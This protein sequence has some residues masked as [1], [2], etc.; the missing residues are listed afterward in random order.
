M[1]QHRERLARWR[2][3]LRERRT[4][5][6]TYRAGV[7]LMGI[8]VLGVGVIA[9]PYPGPGWAIVFV[10]LG[11][12][13]T[14]FVWAQRLLR[15]IKA[16]YDKVMTWFGEQGLWVKAAGVALTTAVVLVTLW[17]VGALGWSARLVGIDSP[18]LKSPV[19]VG[20]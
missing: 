3:K 1:N 4:T 5:N 14:E 13:A 16:R 6:I 20:S 12:L 15:Y 19:G 17:L 11:I 9:I 7:G 10:G 2:E 18:V 8:A